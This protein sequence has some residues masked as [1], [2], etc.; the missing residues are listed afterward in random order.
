MSSADLDPCRFPDNVT[1][2]TMPVTDQSRTDT[3]S[4]SHDPFATPG[5]PLGIVIEEGAH[6]LGVRRKT[7]RKIAVVAVAVVGVGSLLYVMFR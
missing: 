4:T 6:C 3:S 1:S 5:N 2:P 7:A